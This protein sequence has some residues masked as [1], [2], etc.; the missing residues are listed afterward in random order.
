MSQEQRRRRSDLVLEDT[1]KKVKNLAVQLSQGKEDIKEGTGR[2]KEEVYSRES[3]HCG[4][5]LVGC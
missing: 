3:S 1:V 2:Y 5:V 4:R